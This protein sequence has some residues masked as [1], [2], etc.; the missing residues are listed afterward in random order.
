MAVSLNQKLLTLGQL[1]LVLFGNVV[2]S[3]LVDW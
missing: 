1:F 2:G 3:P